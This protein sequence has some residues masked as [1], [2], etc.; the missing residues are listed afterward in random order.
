M[1]ISI[2]IGS[3]VVNQH[4]HATFYFFPSNPVQ[5]TL[6]KNGHLLSFPQSLRARLGLY[7]RNFRCSRC[8]CI[9]KSSNFVVAN[10]RDSRRKGIIGSQIVLFGKLIWVISR[11]W[12]FGG[13]KKDLDLDCL[14]VRIRRK[15]GI[16]TSTW[17]R[18]WILSLQ[19]YCEPSNT[20][21]I[22]AW[23]LCLYPFDW[24]STFIFGTRSPSL[25][26]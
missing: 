6:T 16:F 5:S 9:Q 1:H 21:S 24:P 20:L 3:L 8:S 4:F 18:E 23:L 13:L 25:S 2:L 11:K 26:Y 14:S 7:G 15:K 12:G 22:L 10:R 17:E 19:I